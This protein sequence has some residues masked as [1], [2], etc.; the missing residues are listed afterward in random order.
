MR[1]SYP[2]YISFYTGLKFKIENMR[3]QRCFAYLHIESRFRY[4]LKCK[5]R[6]TTHAECIKFS[7]VK[8][9]II[10]HAKQATKVCSRCTV[11]C[12]LYGKSF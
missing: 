10:S 9:S 1:F 7:H 5:T 2:G 8:I 6:L 3:A 11:N 12:S 4:K